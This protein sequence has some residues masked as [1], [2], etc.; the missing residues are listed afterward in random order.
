MKHLLFFL[1]SIISLSAF[2]QDYDSDRTTLA[3][4]GNYFAYPK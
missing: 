1:L 4:R 3:K 2:A